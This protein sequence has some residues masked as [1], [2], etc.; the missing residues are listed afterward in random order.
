MSI[1]YDYR[2]EKPDRYAAMA[3][4]LATMTFS[5]VLWAPLLWASGFLLATACAFFSAGWSYAWGL[6]T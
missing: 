5:A 6:F 3:W 1:P 2:E 4:K